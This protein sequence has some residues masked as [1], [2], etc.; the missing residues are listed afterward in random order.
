M[1]NLRSFG[2]EQPT[3]C[4]RGIYPAVCAVNAR[5]IAMDTTV[6]AA[7]IRHSNRY[8]LPVRSRRLTQSAIPLGGSPRE[9]RSNLMAIRSFH[10]KRLH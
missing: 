8:L 4:D 9:A 1:E 6:V 7:I 10:G 2:E 5:R 3:A